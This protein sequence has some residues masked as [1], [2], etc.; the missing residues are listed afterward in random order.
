[1][2]KKIVLKLVTYRGLNKIATVLQAIYLKWFSAVKYLMVYFQ[3]IFSMFL[4]VKSIKG[5]HGLE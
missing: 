5:Q 1:M 3:F 4:G 2:M